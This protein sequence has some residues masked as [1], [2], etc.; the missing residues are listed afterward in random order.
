MRFWVSLLLLAGLT[1]CAGADRDNSRYQ[2][3]ISA[4]R[5]VAAA[6]V[7]GQASHALLDWKARQLCT[8]GYRIIR[9][10]VMTADRGNE[11]VDNHIA[12]TG[13]HPSI[14][15]ATLSLPDLSLSGLQ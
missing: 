10:D 12:C 14:D 4:E 7:E 6:P 2:F 5:P 8:I 13:Y 15:L 3:G 9:Q 1:A 11:I